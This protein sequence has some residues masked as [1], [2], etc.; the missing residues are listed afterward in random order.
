MGPSQQPRIT[1]T[2]CLRRLHLC[3]MI[4]VSLLTRKEVPTTSKVMRPLTVMTQHLKT[5][6]RQEPSKRGMSTIRVHMQETCPATYTSSISSQPPYSQ[7]AMLTTIT[8]MAGATF[9]GAH[10]VLTTR[11]SLSSTQTQAHYPAGG[12][13]GR[14]R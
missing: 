1:A 14:P 5:Q 2:S 7:R 13:R 8:R 11:P 4:L 9:K 12:M 3:Q 10:K 6:C